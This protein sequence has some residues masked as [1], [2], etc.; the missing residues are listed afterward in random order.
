[1]K[2]DHPIASPRAEQEG[3]EGP[4]ACPTQEKKKAL[5][6]GSCE[7]FCE[8]EDTKATPIAQGDSEA[9]TGHDA[10]TKAAPIAQGHSEAYTGHDASYIGKEGVHGLI[11]SRLLCVFFIVSGSFSCL[12]LSFSLSFPV[13]LS[14]SLFL[15]I[16]LPLI[17]YSTR[18]LSTASGFQVFMKGMI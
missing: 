7:H 10:D 4:S 2:S 15:T 5:S 18:T 11:F 8:C 6:S 1:M 16:F 13:S 12:T 3:K 9:Y 14:F 17:F